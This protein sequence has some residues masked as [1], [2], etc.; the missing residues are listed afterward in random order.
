M[1]TYFCLFL[2]E[3]FRYFWQLLLHKIMFF[4]SR[5]RQQLSKQNHNGNSN[6]Q[7]GFTSVPFLFMLCSIWRQGG[8]RGKGGKVMSMKRKTFYPEH[9]K[10][11]FKNGNQTFI[12]RN[13]KRFPGQWNKKSWF[14]KRQVKSHVKQK[15]GQR[16]GGLNGKGAD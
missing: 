3:F 1:T 10:S 8:I 13:F 16:G 12:I 2:P 15:I 6:V 4:S 7:T 11:I 9:E 5:I 14:V